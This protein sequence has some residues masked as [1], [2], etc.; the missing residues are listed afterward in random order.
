MDLQRYLLIGA[1]AV[2]SFMLLTE[3]VAFKDQRSAEIAESTSRITTNGGSATPP[4]AP[5]FF[6]EKSSGVSDDI[7][8]AT[9]ATESP[10]EAATGMQAIGD[11]RI[12]QVY[13]D[14]LKVAIDLKGGDI[15]EVA[16]PAFL[17][18]LDTPDVPFVLLEQNQQ[19]K[20]QLLNQA[21]RV[22][23][24]DALEDEN[25]RLRALL[26]LLLSTYI[27]GVVVAETTGW[28]DESNCASNEGDRTGDHGCCWRKSRSL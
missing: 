21:A 27:L 13:T 28:R 11:D 23:R 19:Q 5:D 1:I 22:Q 26:A 18:R 16:L 6:P 2:L 17:E 25:R 24:L 15:I 9:E 10:T 20:A 8:V 12:I 4:P 3:W 7:P 14:V